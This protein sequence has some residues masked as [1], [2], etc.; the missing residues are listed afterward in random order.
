MEVEW[1]LSIQSGPYTDDT[2]GWHLHV[3]NLSIS[4]VVQSENEVVA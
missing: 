1:A 2:A 4:D 3:T